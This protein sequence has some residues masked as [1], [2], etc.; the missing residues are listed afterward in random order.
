[1]EKIGLK[2]EGY[3]REHKLKQGKWRD[4]FLYSILDYE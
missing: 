2:K 3:S 4:S 1:M